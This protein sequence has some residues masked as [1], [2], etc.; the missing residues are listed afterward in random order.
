MRQKIEQVLPK[1]KDISGEIIESIRDGF[2]IFNETGNI[3]IVN[4]ALCKMTGYQRYELLGTGIPRPYWPQEEYEKLNQVFQKALRHEFSDYELVFKRKNGERFPVIVNNS[5]LMSSDDKSIYF[6]TFIKDITRQRESQQRIIDS[7]YKYNE[8]FHHVP[9]PISER[10]YSE[11]KKYFNTLRSKGVIDFNDYFEH[12]PDEVN[13]CVSLSKNTLFNDTMM[14]VMEAESME[15]ILAFGQD[16]I[17]LKDEQWYNY[18]TIFT[19]LSD[20]NTN[21]SFKGKVRTV[22]DNI[23]HFE[24]WSFVPPGFEDSLS[25]VYA[26]FYDI[27]EQTVLTTELNLNKQN[28]EMLVENRTK[29]LSKLFNQLTISYN[30]YKKLYDT[31]KE[32]RTNYQNQIESRNKFLKYMIHEIKTPLLPILG[33]S[34][35]LVN[36]LH[37]EPYLEMA[38]NINKGA[39]NLAA[40]INELVDLEKVNI[41][42]LELDF[43]P[44][45]PVK[46]LNNSYNYMKAQ[47]LYK[48]QTFKLEISD[49]LPQILG[50][51]NRLQQIIFNLLNNAF[52]FTPYE[53]CIILSGKSDKTDVIIE[54]ADNGHGI[55]K[56]KIKDLFKTN[57]H[58]GFTDEI[59]SGLGIGLVLCHNLVKLHGGKIWVESEVDKG[60]KFIFTIPVKN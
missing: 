45:D 7:E 2:Y 4:D 38:W 50:D 25:R 19:N 30:K 48:N 40:R 41:G 21:F 10:D 12:N 8:F 27:T 36:N 13:Y 46:L 33:T 47:A 20:G 34:D 28:L 3:L 9:I 29:Q 15:E 11:T 31:E 49:L 6:I 1:I 56:N 14:S 51:Y 55:D 37:E 26:F 17:K 22:K 32:L 24:I 44:I 52:K 57:I 59:Y 5:L 58:G 42:K 53:G 23:K 35:L 60:A 43:I 16:R 39:Q 54:V 18:K